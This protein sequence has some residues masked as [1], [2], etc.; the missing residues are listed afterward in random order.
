MYNTPWGLRA[1][2]PSHRHSLMEYALSFTD[3][4]V[5]DTITALIA[6]NVFGRFPRLKVLS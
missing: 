4:P 2:P 1:H 3:R 5:A 6:D